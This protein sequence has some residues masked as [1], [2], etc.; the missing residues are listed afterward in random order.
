MENSDDNEISAT[1]PSCFHASTSS[2]REQSNPADRRTK[3]AKFLRGEREK[4]VAPSV[5]FQSQQLKYLKEDI[6][7][8]RKLIDKDEEA[9]KELLIEAKKMRETMEDMSKAMTNCFQMIISMLQAQMQPQMCQ[10]PY[11]TGLG[12]HG[13]V[14]HGSQRQMPGPVVHIKNSRDE[15]QNNEHESFTTYSNRE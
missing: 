9:E 12:V 4:R 15:W 7:I 5:S 10:H 8:K 6:E 3:I 11:P 13:H 2:A 14:F 1:S